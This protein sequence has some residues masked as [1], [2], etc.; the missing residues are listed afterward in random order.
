MNRSF[1]SQSIAFLL[2][3]IFLFIISQQV[4]AGTFSGRVV[5]ETGNPVAGV[6]IALREFIGEATEFSKTDDVGAF[7]IPNTTSAV[8]L[9]LHP[10]NKAA[11]S[12]QTVSI[13]GMILYPIRQDYFFGGLI[14]TMSQEADIKDV[15]IT[16]RPRIQ[17]RGRVLSSD[18][19]PLKNTKVLL[20]LS[21]RSIRGSLTEL[22]ADGYF[23]TYVDAPGLYT[24]SVEYQK[25]L[26]TTE[27]ILIKEKQPHEKLVLMLGGKT[28]TN[29]TEDIKDQVQSLS[30]IQ[31]PVHH[32]L[33]GT[34]PSMW[35]KSTFSGRVVDTEGNAISGF[36]LGIQPVQFIHGS[37]V[38]EIF[39]RDSVPTEKLHTLSVSRINSTGEF[40]FTD[41]QFGPLQLFILPDDIPIDMTKLPHELRRS[42]RLGSE[43][44]I[45][46]IKIGQMTIGN[47]TDPQLFS[48]DRFTFAFKPGTAI[49]NVEITVK[50]RTQIRG[51]IVYADG[52][53][54]NDASVDIKMK[55][56][57][58]EN[59]D[60]RIR[61]RNDGYSSQGSIRTDDDGYFAVYVEKPGDYFFRVKYIVLTAEAGPIQVKNK[62][63][64]NEL[65]LKLNGNLIFTDTPRHVIEAQDSTHPN[66]PQIPDVWVV[67]PTNG[68][69]YKLIACEDWH[70]AHL[71]ATKNDA[72]LVSINDEVE[73]K[74]ITEVFGNGFFWIGLNDLEK[75]GE[76][77]W[78]GG[79]PATYISWEPNEIYPEGTLSDAEKD[80][81]VMNNRGAWQATAPD[82]TVWIMTR[83]AILEKD[84]LL[85]TVQPKSNVEGK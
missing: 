54:L 18:G 51:R 71:Q 16:V 75:E 42:P 43:F 30:Q 47:K 45:Q 67:N 38:P 85:S 32:S 28:L 39:F 62:V 77:Q 81:V 8:K 22:D 35:E 55:E 57:Q 83:Q 56:P 79:E 65:I 61:R 17:I 76:W 29:P 64:Q 9:M 80:Y 23:E 41:I 58:N 31:R 5:D 27:E 3:L 13:A 68:H 44:E 12:I 48:S 1:F 50:Q 7:S 37:V 6:T 36:T 59:P 84:G 52:T 60:A 24:V 34:E 14:F 40:S 66:D 15:E 70:D 49:E 82:A 20:R 53:P 19:T 11:Y 33:P 25:M 26:A 69:A 10:E 63:Q 73:H 72:H 74:W 4:F 78:D 2:S 21:G 46:S